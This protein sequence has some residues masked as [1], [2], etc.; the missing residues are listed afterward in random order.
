MVTTRSKRFL[1][2]ISPNAIADPSPKRKKTSTHFSDQEEEVVR[3]HSEEKRNSEINK[4]AKI[5]RTAPPT[6]FVCLCG[7]GVKHKC[8]ISPKCMCMRYADANPG[9][10]LFVTKG[11]EDLFRAWRVEQVK[12]DAEAF[13]VMAY[14][15]YSGYG[16]AEVVGNMLHAFDQV[17][18]TKETDAWI[19]WAHIEGMARFL[20]QDNWKFYHIDDAEGNGKRVML[21]GTALLTALDHLTAAGLLRHDSAIRNIGF[22]IGLFLEF[23]VTYEETCE[24]NEDGWRFVVVL[25]LD[26]FG[27]KISGL[28]AAEQIAEG[29]RE[30]TREVEEAEADEVEKEQRDE[31]S[32]DLDDKDNGPQKDGNEPNFVN[33]YKPDSAPDSEVR[34]WDAW[35]WEQEVKIYTV[36]HGIDG[37]ID[38]KQYDLTLAENYESEDDEVDSVDSDVVESETGPEVEVLD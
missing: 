23:V 28:K 6:T 5:D 38:G 32:S 13:G 16:T 29:L 26:A 20:S 37:K 24:G 31:T 34:S 19:I 12:R 21:I 3:S 36:W 7:N 33:A 22:V 1:S 4:T 17:I 10:P 25:R 11:G 14:T 9:H 18:N 30:I 8:R 15:D 27:I 2:E 35:S